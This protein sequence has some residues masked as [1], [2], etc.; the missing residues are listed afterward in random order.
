MKTKTKIALVAW[1]VLQCWFLDTITRMP[2]PTA[3]ELIEAYSILCEYT[4]YILAIALGL[5]EG[6][7][8]MYIAKAK[9]FNDSGGQC[10]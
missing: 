7:K 3:S 4:I 5:R 2:N 8:W 9:K 1:I 10:E 6:S